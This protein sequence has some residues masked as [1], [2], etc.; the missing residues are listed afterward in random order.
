MILLAVITL[1]QSVVLILCV[2]QMERLRRQQSITERAFK[3][4]AEIQCSEGNWNYDE[5]QH[6]YANGII[7][8]R[9][10]ATG[11]PCEFL[12]APAEGYLTDRRGSNA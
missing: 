5:Y 2:R 9:A 10:I 8:G 4:C 6:G 11:A 12:S 7:L 1:I 3:Q